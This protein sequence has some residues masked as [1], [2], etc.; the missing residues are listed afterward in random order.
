MLDQ[1]DLEAI[2]NLLDK[3]LGQSE[4]LVHGEME[5]TRGI[6]EEQINQVKNN[7]D[8]LD[9]LQKAGAVNQTGDD[10]YGQI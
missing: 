3:R 8:R 10:P 4:N 6:L 9:G 7:S 5:R 2:E 1:K